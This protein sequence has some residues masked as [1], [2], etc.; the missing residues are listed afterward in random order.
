MVGM[1]F[2]SFFNE[3]RLIVDKLTKNFTSDDQD[4]LNPQPDSICSAACEMQCYPPTDAVSAF[5][6]ISSGIQP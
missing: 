5:N 1:I 6:D 2:A 4:E 3:R